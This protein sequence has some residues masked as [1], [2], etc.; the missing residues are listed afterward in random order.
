MQKQASEYSKKELEEVR[1]ENNALKAQL[2]DLHTLAEDMK[3]KENLLNFYKEKAIK[4]DEILKVQELNLKVLS[5][6][7]ARTST[8]STET[9]KLR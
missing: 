8:R 7:R 6:L 2:K 3:S 1:S 5:K 9:W 4:C